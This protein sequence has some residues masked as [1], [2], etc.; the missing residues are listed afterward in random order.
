MD[1]A[2]EEKW[3]RGSMQSRRILWPLRSRGEADDANATKPAGWVQSPPWGLS[4]AGGATAAT[5]SADA[6]GRRISLGVGVGIPRVRVQIG[7]ALVW[8]S[9][10]NRAVDELCTTRKICLRSQELD[11]PR[12]VDGAVC[13]ALTVCTTAL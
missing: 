2:K 9:I 13:G 4:T 5:A 11:Y 1:P 6:P 10:D 3:S 7:T 12:P 8:P